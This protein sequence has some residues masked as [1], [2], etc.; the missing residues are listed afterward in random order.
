MRGAHGGRRHWGTW[1]PERAPGRRWDWEAFASPV[2]AAADVQESVVIG[3]SA[4]LVQDSPARWRHERRLASRC[5]AVVG[6]RIEALACVARPRASCGP[7]RVACP[8]W[9]WYGGGEP[10]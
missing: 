3:A 6:V 2:E 9:S 7:P 1:N 8:R 10:W 4:S 5:N